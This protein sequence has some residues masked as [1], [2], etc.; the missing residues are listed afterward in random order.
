MKP[1]TILK[2]ISSAII[3]FIVVVLAWNLL[4]NRIW[5]YLGISAVIIDV[6]FILNSWLRK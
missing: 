3:E 2:A 5:A 4:E 6:F 1:L